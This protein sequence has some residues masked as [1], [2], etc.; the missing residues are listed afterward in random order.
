MSSQATKL[1]RM[2]NTQNMPSSK[3]SSGHKESRRINIIFD[4]DGTL[5]STKSGKKFPTTADDYKVIW[6]PSIPKTVDGRQVFT[7]IHTNQSGN[8]GNMCDKKVAE[9][10]KVVSAVDVLVAREDDESRKPIPFG[11]I[12]MIYGED[13]MYDAIPSSSS[14]KETTSSDMMIQ[15]RGDIIIFVG[16][17]AGRDGDH[18]DT[19]LKTA[20]NLSRLGYRAYFSTPEEYADIDF[21]SASSLIK[22][23]KSIRRNSSWTVTYPELTGEQTDIFDMSSD[24]PSQTDLVIMC[25]I[26]GSGKSSIIDNFRKDWK[27]ITYGAKDKTY[28]DVRNALSAGLKVVVDGT[29]PRREV[30]EMFADLASSPIIIY[31]DTP[32]DLAKHNRKYREIIF[33]SKHIPSIAVSKFL[34][35]FEVPT[36]LIDPCPVIVRRALLLDVDDVVYQLY[37]Y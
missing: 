5:M 16:D 2:G 1:M 20:L 14:S 25:G 12:G 33:G 19:D 11:L 13:G 24:I 7:Y 28:R 23:L 36:E 35:D 21:S 26:Q 31:V 15:R 9:A 22:S 6:R 27:V 3:T 34:K 17:A 32:E 4:V 37:Y 8:L 10:A 18:S 29:F 30:R